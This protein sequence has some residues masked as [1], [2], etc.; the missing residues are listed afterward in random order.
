MDLPQIAGPATQ[1]EY[2][3]VSSPFLDLANLYLE[4]LLVYPRTACIYSQ[5]LTISPP[6]FV[7]PFWTYNS[8]ALYDLLVVF[9]HSVALATFGSL[10]ESS[11]DGGPRGQGGCAP[12]RDCF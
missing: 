1:K 5:T 10:G 2:F 12:S 7:F 11:S 8:A 9:S 4:S 3:L 6:P